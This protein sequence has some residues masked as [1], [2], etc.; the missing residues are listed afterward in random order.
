MVAALQPN[1][2]KGDSPHLCEAPEGPF[3][4]MGTV[5]FSPKPKARSSMAKK[6]ASSKTALAANQVNG[7]PDAEAMFASHPALKM[8]VAQIEK[9]FGEGAIMPLGAEH[10]RADRRH[11]HRQPVAR[12]RPG[13]PG[14]SPRPHRRDLRPRI[15]RQDHAGPARRGP[16]PT[17][18]AASPP[19]STPSTPSTPAGP[20]SWASSWKRCWSASPAAA[21]R[22]CT[23]PKCSSRATPST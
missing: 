5:P 7:K 13:R 10:D 21:K 23:S 11:P 6:A 2:G 9:Q 15:E 17:K 20:R 22:R 1:G 4:Q 14:H 19:S 8:T 18:P 16:G 12:H 3:R